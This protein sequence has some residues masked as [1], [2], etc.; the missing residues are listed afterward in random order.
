MI[1]SHHYRHFVRTRLHSK[2]VS[3]R[4][5]ARPRARALYRPTALD[6]HPRLE[7]RRLLDGSAPAVS[8]LKSIPLMEGNIGLSGKTLPG[9]PIQLQVGVNDPDPSDAGASFTFEIDW[10]DG[11]PVESVSSPVFFSPGSFV[12]LAHTYDTVGTYSV[13]MTAADPAGN[14][15]QPVS[16]AV[17]VADLIFNEIPVLGSSSLFASGSPG[18]DT[19][20]IEAEGPK[21]VR[22]FRNGTFLGTTDGF[23]EIHSGAG[24]DTL[25]LNGP[26]TMFGI[27]FDGGEGSDD[28]IIRIDD[29]QFENWVY[30]R[31]SGSSGSDEIRIEGSDESD[32]IQF[33]AFDSVNVSVADSGVL[34][35]ILDGGIQGDFIESF[36]FDGR[37]GN[38]LIFGGY[39]AGHD[40]ML[41]G[42]EGND[43]IYA[44]LAGDSLFVDGGEGSDLVGLDLIGENQ[45]IVTDSGTS[46]TDVL[47]IY[48][49]ASTH[50]LSVSS[51]Q[52]AMGPRIVTYDETVDS[53]GTYLESGDDNVEV[54]STSV[55]L[56][57][58][59][60][61]GS[62]LVT[63]YL[64]NLAG[65]VTIEDSGTDGNDS[66]LAVGTSGSDYIDKRNSRITLND[67]A[68][69]SIDYDG[70]EEV[71]IQGGDGNDTIIDPGANTTIQGGDGDDTIVITATAP[72][73]VS[74]DG[75][76]GSDMLTVILGSLEGAVLVDDTGS[77]GTD[78]LRID[79]TASGGEV[80]IESGQVSSGSEVV[81]YEPKLASL[82]VAPGDADTSV[83]ITSVSAAGVTL[84]A[85][86]GTTQVTV[87]LGNLEGPVAVAGSANA[88]TVSVAVL[89]AQGDNAIALTGS[90]LT[91]GSESLSIETQ[92]EGLAVV[93]D[94]GTTQITVTALTVPVG[95][96]SLI[97]GDS[98]STFTFV[99]MGD[100]PVE[101]VAVQGG[102][103]PDS[104]VV[105]EVV[106]SPPQVVTYQ[107]L[108]PAIAEVQASTIDEGARL[109]L[110][111]SFTDIDPDDSW[112]AT[113]DY[114]DGSGPAT[115]AL[116]TD[117]TFTLDH[118]F[119]GRGEYVVTV[120]VI[121]SGQK[122]SKRTIPITV[123]NVAPV[124]T[125][126][127]PAS[128]VRGQSRAF[129]LSGSDVSPAD[130]AFGFTY[131]I[132]WGDGSPG[133]NV[134][135]HDTLTVDHVFEQE[136]TYSIHVTAADR[137]GAV[138]SVATY[139]IGIS[140][141]EIQPD[142]LAPNRRVL[143]VGGS[144]G[145]DNLKIKPGT[146][147]GELKVVIR[148]EE[149]ELFYRHKFDPVI[150]R[151]VV[152]G[153]D[154]DDDIVVKPGVNV[155]AWLF[156]GSGDDRLKGGGADDILMGGDG[157]DVLASNGGR[158]ILIGGLGA[159]K[160]VGDGGDDLLIS[161]SVI[162]ESL[163][164]ALS[165]IQAE[166]TSARSYA[167]RVANLRG[168]GTGPRLNGLTFLIM[169]GPARNVF[170]DGKKDILTGG[171]GLDWF[172][173]DLDG[174]G[175]KP[176][177]DKITDL[178]AAEFADDLDFIA[179]Q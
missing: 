89:G 5:S 42:G 168:T 75:Q 82:T 12:W 90:V 59:A 177:K 55:P 111:G 17:E 68:T 38:D 95:I 150:D 1:H 163:D 174:D 73:V 53:I 67:P 129:D 47:E 11:S 127:G 145:A 103:A 8:I 105:V 155:P 25:I 93:G 119:A 142:P 94:S 80:T 31:D 99:D 44:G 71:T 141:A 22:V 63:I 108:A 124:V 69:E 128:G 149:N 165:D 91:S 122:S 120:T 137:D 49:D 144:A 158:D 156:G 13:Q 57:I 62:D 74:I 102:V 136:G 139:T 37:G 48:T 15:S 39:T 41:I 30:L 112:T 19:F 117:K 126:S 32:N 138:S 51:T 20:V 162:F 113:V 110:T 4:N 86:S 78:T 3:N 114:G 125:I 146:H 171:S 143:V 72:G 6:F 160:I 43:R 161:G 36:V 115:L 61:E 87:R 33:D 131:A 40:Y 92:L 7:D 65:A 153:Q 46:G 178:S 50:A 104:N 107:N 66:L 77:T 167:A 172:L 100:A 130:I 116:A 60:G 79:G 101:S 135:A 140:V 179:W 159:D 133:Q 45:A 9:V 10:G 173:A 24:D 151:V 97:G 123:L 29:L 34:T 176:S 18:N 152:Y 27:T 98:E 166:W 118:V 76:N 56:L 121:D 52:V 169:D 109:I 83:S 2:T 147:P 16:T 85:G 164:R 54:V 81:R 134:T 28:Y 21:K 64:G 70:I 148:D 84:L 26:S 106:G 35:V 154:G 88:G 175:D 170:D 157:D 96:L 58:D 14:L 23:L 132:D